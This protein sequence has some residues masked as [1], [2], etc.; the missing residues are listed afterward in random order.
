MIDNGTSMFD[1]W[2]IVTYVAET[3]ANKVAGLDKDGFDIAF[4]VNGETY[5]K[6]NLCGKRGRADFAKAL[7]DGK[8]SIPQ[9]EE[10]H[11]PTD[12]YHTFH[13][14]FRSWEDSEKAPIT[15]IVLTDGR[16]E[17]THPPDLLEKRIIELGKTVQSIFKFEARHCSIGFVHFGNQSTPRLV[18]LDDKLCKDNALK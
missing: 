13:R 15:W 8:P 11:V 9:E 4:T 12:I 2:P 1:Y 17:G 18:Y 16:W 3:L 7:H 5:D 10:Y 6:R 14:L